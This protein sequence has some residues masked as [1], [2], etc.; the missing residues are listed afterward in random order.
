MT[1][2]NENAPGKP[3]GVITSPPATCSAFQ[4]R[5]LEAMG[6]KWVTAGIM[7]DRMW[8]DK[9]HPTPWSKRSAKWQK[10][11]A[12]LN[13]LKELGYVTKEVTEHGQKEWLRLKMPNV[14][15]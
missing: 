7:A 15:S 10:M 9:H 13:K 14:E 2:E 1:T 6:G 5:L 8:P 12:M 11:G 3:E 4:L